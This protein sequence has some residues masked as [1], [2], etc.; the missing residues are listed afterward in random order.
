M[1]IVLSR[2]HPE[3]ALVVAANRDELL[4]RP[5][6]PM[7]VLR[8]DSP[9]ILGGRDLLAGGTWLAVNEHG[10][11]AGLTNRPA[12]AGKDPTRRSRGELPLAIASHA[13]AA[14]AVDAFVDAFRPADYNPAWMLVG[15]REALFFID[16]TGEDGAAVIQPLPPGMHI[17]ENRTIGEPS[18]KVDHVRTLLKG[19]EDLRGEALPALLQAVLANHEAP[20]AT[21]LEPGSEHA[22]H[23]PPAIT[24]ACVH[25]DSYGTRWSGII[26][27]DAGGRVPPS[28][29]Y[30]GGPPCTTGF[31]DATPLW[32]RGGRDETG[33]AVA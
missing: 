22:D 7:A 28:F 31:V 32:S 20:D 26:S 17:L 21:E 8:E 5:A 30:A 14:L 9:R 27:V 12:R 6:E 29:L 11:V 15:D 3:Y 1:L 23:T 24:A 13:S 16:M 4:D 10:L 33:P 2:A 19:A 18:A 25:A